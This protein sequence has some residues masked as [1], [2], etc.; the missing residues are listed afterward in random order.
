MNRQAPGWYVQR[1]REAMS[2][3][4]RS[5]RDAGHAPRDGAVALRDASLTWRGSATSYVV[6]SLTDFF[7]GFRLP[8]S[9]IMEAVGVVVVAPVGKERHG[10][11]SAGV[12]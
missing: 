5:A 1:L 3:V 2:V 11:G 10:G 4:L 6:W 12:V 7:T 9:E 8:N